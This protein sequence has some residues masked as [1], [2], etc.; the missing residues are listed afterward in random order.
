MRKAKK[1]LAEGVYLTEDMALQTKQTRMRGFARDVHAAQGR[2]QRVWIAYPA[3]LFIEGQA[4]LEPFPS[5][6]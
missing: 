2:K 6:N 1:T 4:F 5:F 3:R